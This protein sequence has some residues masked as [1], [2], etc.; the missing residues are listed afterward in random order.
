[1]LQTREATM[2][3]DHP[4]NDDWFDRPMR[5]AQLVLAE[6]DP[7]QFDLEFWLDYFR[8]THAGGAC[9]SAGGYVAYYPTA[10]P[11]HHR[12]R[13]LGDGDPFGDLVAGCREMGMA[14]LART[15]P[16][17]VHQ[18][19]YE[20]H[21][22]WIAVDA[23]GRRRRHWSTPDAWVTCALGPYNQEFMTGVH[24]EIVERYRVDGVFS[25]RWAGH[26]V[27]YCEHCRRNFFDACA[28]DLPRTRDPQDARWRS[29]LL[30]RQERL[31]DLCR[32]WDAEIRR[33][34]PDACYVPNS[35]GGALS[36]LDM[37]SL[38]EMIPLLFA[39]RQ[40][41]R[42]VMPPWENGKNAKEFRAAFGRKP[43]GGIFSVG[44]EEEHRWKDSTQ[45][46]A[47]LRIWMAE[48]IANGM[49]PWFV[50]FCGQ[51]HDRRWL[52]VVEDVF[53]WHHSAEPYLRNRTSLA[54]VGVV[55]SQ[56]SAA[57]YGG[58]RARAKVEAPIL[59]VYQALVEAR[60]PFEMV[61]D[62]LLD[63]E[64][65]DRFKTLVLPNVA[66]LSDE[67]CRQ[68]AGFCARGGSV[69]AT[70]ET[71]L[72]DEW[73]V[74]RA[75][76]GLADLFGVDAL[77]P[78][79]GPVKNA[80]LCPEHDVAARYAPL[81]DG[82]EDAGRIVDGVYRVPVEAREPLPAPPLT[83]VPP[84]PDL[85]ME[86]V[87]P[88]RPRTGEPGVYLRDTG[89]GRVVYFPWDVARLFWEI[90]NVDHGRLLA[91]AVRWA[92]N[93][94][95]PVAVTGPGLLDVT[96]WRQAGSLTVHLVNLTNPMTMRGPFREL[97]GV[98]EQLVRLRL[99]AGESVRRVQLLRAGG[100]PRVEEE[101]GFA[102]VTVPGVLVHE[103]V[104]IDL[105]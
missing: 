82:L 22:D 5:W 54:R 26:G 64:H 52:R 100:S 93:E 23:E 45:S 95:P 8:R 88:R 53:S 2:Q 101:P 103:V 59:G 61:H 15:D 49:R 94:E 80:Y 14:V 20:A 86:E 42:G 39:D 85:P 48:G 40:G 28:L 44:L 57:Y 77:G 24:K 29:Y 102:T 79:E 74:L 105:E 10:I 91:N 66:A 43:V 65:V 50:K 7:G 104:A 73:G 68:I 9:L 98:G 4:S 41:R 13:W 78:A 83:R 21:P 90:L 33:V 67:Q 96:A 36:D 56:Q 63:R 32:L 69:V 58:E 30:W 31:F 51:L 76:F 46:E 27:C 62:R 6:N 17:A 38:G 25:N 75:S 71:S 70:G 72:Y 97:I 60:V 35:G 87:Y 12:S 19:V 99:P 89:G 84:Y 92:T 34:N 55:Y 18:D 3:S 11:L 81:L 47:E 37:R 1:M 16:H